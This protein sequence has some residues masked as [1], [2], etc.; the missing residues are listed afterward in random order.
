VERRYRDR[1]AVDDLADPHLLDE[2]RVALDELTT[3]LGLGGDFYPSSAP[4]RLLRGGAG[5]EPPPA[6]A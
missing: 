2:S 3:L 4:D 6:S 5:G 1:L